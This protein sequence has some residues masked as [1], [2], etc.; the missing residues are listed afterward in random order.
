MLEDQWQ[1]YR[2]TN[3]TPPVLKG[4]IGTVGYNMFYSVRASDP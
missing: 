3:C 2:F 1:I 4:Q